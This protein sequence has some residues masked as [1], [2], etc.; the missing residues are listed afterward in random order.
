MFS[1]VDFF[2]FSLSQLFHLGGIELVN[3]TNYP[4]WFS[5]NTT[6]VELKCSF[7]GWPRPRIFWRIPDRKKLIINGSESFY[8]TEKL[9]GE[10][11]ITSF[12]R[13]PNIQQ[14]HEG[15]YECLAI[16]TVGV[17]E[18]LEKSQKIELLYN[19]K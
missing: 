5:A 2:T 8:L 16:T 14:K 10:D 15:I 18:P 4:V 11:T 13:N 1:N 6:L 3:I 9:V 12:L 7:K 17:G 19:C